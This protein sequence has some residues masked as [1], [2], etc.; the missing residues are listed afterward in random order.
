VEEIK[1]G[2]AIPEKTVAIID[3]KCTFTPHTSVGFKGNKFTIENED[4]VLHT[5]H[6]YTYISGKTIFNI[7]LPEKGS[8]V[9]KTLTKTGIMEL[10]CDC[11]PW[12]QGFVYVFDNPYVAVT[13]EKG[14]FVIENIP[15]GTYS[16]AAWHEALGNIRLVDVRVESGKAA[17]IKLQYTPEINLY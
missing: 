13:D 14:E 12:M 1:A 6:V 8:L 16:V 10:N 7:G 2:K 9:T 17:K 5:I 3:A 11:H 4:P 15:P